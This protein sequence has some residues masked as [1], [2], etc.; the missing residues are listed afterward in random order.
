MKKKYVR[1]MLDVLNDQQWKEVRA[2][3]S[4]AF[5]TGKIKKVNEH[6]L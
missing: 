5:T 6:F 3:V 2:A 4:P 1:K